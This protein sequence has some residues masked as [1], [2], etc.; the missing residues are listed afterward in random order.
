MK[1][2]WPL[3]LLIFSWPAFSAERSIIY[4][5]SSDVTTLDPGR[6]EDTYSSEVIANLFEGLVRFRR[7]S[8]AIEPAL[9]DHWQVENGGKI[10]RFFLRRGVKFHNQAGFNAQAVVYSFNHRIKRSGSDYPNWKQHLSAIQSVKAL[11]R[12]TVEIVLDKPYAPFL[13]LLAL[14]NAYIVAPGSY[15]S[16]KFRPIG[17]GPFCFKRR[18]AG[19]SLIIERFPG[20]WDGTARVDRVTF[21]INRDSIWRLLKIKNGAADI[22]PIQSAR[23]YEEVATQS[24]I[25]FV[26]SPSLRILYLGF[27]LRHKPFDQLK[28]R[29]AF[30]CLLDKKVL[31][32]LVFQNL[33]Q[34]IVMPLPENLL[35][36]NIK[37][38]EA[39]PNIAKAQKLLKQAGLR[40]G[41]DCKLYF[42]EGQAGVKEIADRL[43]MNAGL[44][45]IRMRK[46]SLPFEKLR[47][48]A[49]AGLHDL[50]IIGFRTAPD[51]DLYLRSLFTDDR[52]SNHSFYT[53]PS[54]TDLLSRGNQTMVEADR[55]EIYRQALTIIDRD[56]PIIPLLSI[57]NVVAHRRSIS[58]LYFSPLG[59][60]M[61]K[62]TEKSGQ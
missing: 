62:E 55:H 43:A 37:F 39:A 16:Q 24:G 32:K 28:V 21:G 47:E 34:P 15:D 14:P 54:L 13:A 59:H 44:A 33:A 3:F 61:F 50:L 30:R 57:N 49:Q 6:S 10:W 18:T 26:S 20:Y 4:L 27:N 23:E 31:A 29:Q 51:A 8:F 9:A 46:N 22:V 40:N 53:N 12:F 17:T 36:A 38:S 56:V 48:I 60:L 5:R 19:Q 41:F 1:R 42:A 35:P 7:D 25:G 45:N 11:D 2:W 52:T 58:S